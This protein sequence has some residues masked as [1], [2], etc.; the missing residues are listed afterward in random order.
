[1]E[2]DNVAIIEDEPTMSLHASTTPERRDG[3]VVVK[4]E[5][6]QGSL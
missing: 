3:Y 1:M 4:T 5:S 2:R 6:Y